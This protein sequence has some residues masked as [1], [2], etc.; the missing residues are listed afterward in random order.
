[1]SEQIKP[2]PELDPALVI[3][4]YLWEVLKANN[5]D[6]WDEDKYGGLVPIVPLS[7]EPELMEFGGPHITYLPN[8][9]PSNGARSFGQLTFVVGDTN[10][11]RLMATLNIIRTALDRADETARDINRFSST[12]NPNNSSPVPFLGI[13]FGTVR[14]DFT[15]GPTG[16]EVEGG[17][18]YAIL[19]IEYEYYVDYNVVTQV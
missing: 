10:F 11:R 7:E 4:A 3:R 9:S 16:S 8:W 15:E 18:D 13:R 2:N 17:R 5:P 12:Y 19:A 14:T 1:M 6:V